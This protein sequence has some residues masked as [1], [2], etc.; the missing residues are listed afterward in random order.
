M[1]SPAFDP[2]SLDP[3]S[4]IAEARERS[5]LQDFGDE[6][7]REPLRRMLEAIETEANLNEGGRMAQRDRTIGL[8][9]NRLRLEDWL[10]RHPEIRDEELRVPVVVCGLPRTGTTMLHRLLASD[11]DTLAVRWFECRYPAPFEGND[12]TQDDARIPAAKEEIRQ[13]LEAVPGLATVHPWDAEGPDEEI[14]LLEN[15]FLAWM[16]EAHAHVPEFGRW[17]REQDRTPA[18]DYLKL[19]LRF[20]QWQKRRAGDDASSWVLKAPYHLGVVEV[21]LEAF[22]DATV[23]QTHRDPFETIP[24]ICSLQ[25]FMWQLACDEPDPLQC[26]ALWGKNWEIALRHALE[27]RDSRYPDRFLDIWYR[28]VAKDPVSQV[29]RIYEATGRKL[30]PQAEAAARKWAEENRRENRPPHEY[31]MEKFGFSEE[32][33]AAA[34]REYRERFILSHDD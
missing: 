16:P 7:F 18:Y 15:T 14:M 24:S 23:V 17:V 13:L 20:L 27:M 2:R 33:L 4:I 28:D 3:D 5:G 1:A 8:L 21:L 34:F 10:T 26:G 32:K 30:S 22:P 6:S 9:V 12:W 19:L 31:T 11:P 25:L 29:K